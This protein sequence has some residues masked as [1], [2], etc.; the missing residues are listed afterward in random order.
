[1]SDQ[2]AA[3]SAELDAERE[4]DLRSIL[5]RIA[6]RWWLLVVGLVVGAALGA[7]SSSG[8]GGWYEAK[9]LV[10]LGQTYAPGGG[11]LHTLET[12]PGIIKQIVES[13]PVLA[14]AAA[15]SDLSPDALKGN[16]TSR[17]VSASGRTTGG[18]AP[19]IQVT[20]LNPDPAKAERAAA[21]V[22]SSV[23]GQ[24]STYV[25]RKIARLKGQVEQNDKAIAAAQNQLREALAARKVALSD[26]RLSLSDRL[27]IQA[28]S[29]ATLQFYE[30]RLSN[31]RADRTTALQL[32][33]LATEVE[34]GRVVAPTPALRTPV[35][36]RRN[37]IVI[38]ALIGLL[39][40]TFAAY[41]VEPLQRLRKGRA[42]VA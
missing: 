4:I 8:G 22:A 20:V 34:R 24:L 42:Q 40:G 13:E 1:M 38:G 15:A 36:S 27:L 31:R 2:H 9:S 18:L 3:S 41:L 30:A 12:Y 35:V 6:D 11:Q 17:P 25:D 16:V 32:L 23:L 5:R 19:L 39:V 21:A 26:K 14:G 28:N 37:P 7:L 33:D 29:N 10:Y